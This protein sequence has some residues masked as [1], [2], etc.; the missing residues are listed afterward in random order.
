MS[1]RPEAA[2]NGARSGEPT[3]FTAA[4]FWLVAAVAGMIAFF[5]DGFASLPGAWSS[6]EYSHGPI[7]PLIAAYLALR[8]LREM[9]A[10]DHRYSRLPGLA[11][12]IAGLFLGLIGNLAH[13]PDIITYGLLVTLG[14]FILILAGWR[15]G[16]RFWPA[17]LFLFFMLPLPNTLYWPLSTK[18]QLI[19]SRLG[20]EL[21]QQLNIPVYLDGNIIDLGNYKLQVAEACNGLRYLFPLMS[22]GFLFAVL[23]RGPLWHRIVLFLS[24]MPITI[25]MNSFRIGVI[26]ILVNRFGTAQAEGFLHYFEGWIIFI[27]CIVALY[28]EAFLLQRLV[29]RPQPVLN[30]IDLDMRGLGAGLAG[31]RR[32]PA[33]SALITAAVLLL[34]CGV[35]WQVVPARTAEPVARQRLAMF[36][37]QIDDRHGNAIRLEPVIERVLKADD[38]LL[39][40]YSGNGKLPVNL[41]ISYYA[42]QNA[43]A[44]I[45]SPEVCIPGGGWEVSR[46]A[47]ARIRV[48]KGEG[49]VLDVNRAIIQKG[50]E[51]QLVY[52]WFDERGRRF[53]NDYVAKLYSIWDSIVMGRSDGALVRVVTPIAVRENEADAD[54]RLSGFLDSI[55]PLMPSFVPGA[56]A[57]S[58]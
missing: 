9:P 36:P 57:S 58:H 47:Q 52:Y 35:L 30:I 24:T 32:I 42:A 12:V 37:M 23:Y 54:R 55:L 38:Y 13:I 7:I 48:G 31:I 20:V 2:A 26:G 28:I 8:E 5:W 39:A 45:H 19:S 4:H 33:T 41:L 3:V 14:G 43:G 50:L 21:I 46:W 10:S 1:I 51:R 25:G 17:W 34:A 11:V 53:T 6:P 22:F 29:A 16:L 44:G 15:R 49:T 18:L 56:S 27:A 40:D